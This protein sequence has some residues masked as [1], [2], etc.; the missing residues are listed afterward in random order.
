MQREIGDYKIKYMLGAGG[1]GTVYL[2]E[3]NNNEYALKQL[4]IGI[5]NPEISNRF[6]LES[7]RIDKL[8][9]RYHLEYVVQIYDILFEQNAYV[10]E[11]IPVSSEDYFEK[12]N[13]EDFIIY[14]IRAFHQLHE[15]EIVHRDIKPKNLRVHDSR[16]VIIDFGVSS[17]WDSGSKISQVGTKFYSPPEVVVNIFSEYGN[18]EA[19]R[20]AHSELLK[21]K[22]GSAIE[23]FKYVKKLHDV[24]SLGITIG[25]FLTGYHPFTQENYIAYLRNGELEDY[26]RWLEKIPLRFKEFVKKATAFSP[27]KRPQLDALLKDLKVN[28]FRFSVSGPAKKDDTYCPDSYFKCLKCAH[29]TLPPAEHCDKCREKLGTIML[30]IEPLQNIKTR[31]TPGSLRLI[32]DP[33]LEAGDISIV[34]DL[35]G[36]DFEIL[37]GRSSGSCHIAFRSDNWMSKVHGRLIKKDKKVYY[38]DGCDGEQPTNSG[39]FN[40]LPIGNSRIELTSG[41]LLILGSTIF[42]IKKYFGELE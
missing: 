36:E 19:A 8:R 29:E 26:T 40:N 23:R 17:W 14:L 27:L 35:Q 1:F 16:P 13:D 41:A 25:E 37:M 34:V 24:Y 4:E 6:I 39:L 38:I 3:H 42:K 2:V 28:P 21:I 33:G 9:E 22:P 10:M 5:M 7:K 12:D 31:E 18:L 11:Y 15:L 30:H 20:T 32:R